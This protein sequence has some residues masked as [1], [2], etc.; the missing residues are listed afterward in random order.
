MTLP[1]ERPLHEYHLRLDGHEWTI[2]GQI[3]RDDGKYYIL[4]CVG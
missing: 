1:V 4:E 3:V 2:V